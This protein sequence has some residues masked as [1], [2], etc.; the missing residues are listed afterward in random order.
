[1]TK[2]GIFPVN[3]ARQNLSGQAATTSI[4]RKVNTARPI[5]VLLGE[6]GKLLLRPQQ[7]VIGDPKDITGTKSPNTIVDQTLDD[8]QKALKNK[9]I[10]D[11]GCSRH[12]TGNKAYIVEYQDYNGG[13]VAFG[14]SKGY[15]SGKGKIKTRK[16]D[17]EDVCFVKELQHFN[18]FSVSQMCDK[19]NK[20]LFTDTECLVL[21]PDFK[22]PD[23]NQ[24]LL[25]VPR[26]NN[27]YSFN[28]EFSTNIASAVICLATNQK[29]NFSKLIFDGMLRNLDNPKKK[30]L[31]YL[32]F[33]MV[34]L[35]NQIE[36]GEP[37]NDVY[38]TP[39]HTLKVF[40]NM[41]RKGLK[42][43]GR[44]TP[45]FSTMLA[46]AEVEEGE[47]SSSGPD[48]THSPSINLEGTGG[49]EGD[50][51]QLSNDS[52]HSSGNTSERA[53]G[54]LNLEEL[55]SLCTNL[56]NRVLALETAKDAQ[57]AKI[58]K[59]NIRIKKLEKKCKPN[60]SHHK[61]WLKS[62]KM[63]SMKKRLGK[64]EPVSKQGRKNVKLGPTLDTFDDL[65]VDLVHGMDY[66]DTEEA[67]TEGRQS[68]ETGE[69]KG[70]SNEE[71]VNV[72]GNIGVSI[73][74]NISTASRP[75]VST[76]TPMT[77]PTITNVFEDE[78]IFLVDALVML[79]D[80]AKL[81]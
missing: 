41:S 10:V 56:S 28:L 35:N 64:K 14:G 34:F 17:F 25:R 33:L 79:S 36:L 23:E 75:E 53:E 5:L 21:S 46:S 81:K 49:N 73:V 78:D 48:N 58:L 44:I 72:A 70:G 42:F 2:T 66:M 69:Q 7:V 43:S 62:V 3:T 71:P 55:L 16:L 68:K 60:I 15:I 47:E 29:F 24:V 61:A 31:M 20:V 37:F 6:I 67:V 45:L 9:G 12:M 1:L 76:T 51:V 52:P 54:G 4:A 22:L 63:L 40:S 27:I 18:L 30:F 74:V 8:P 26:Q 38:I 11:S 13:P 59:L 57:A 39:A 65:D 32:R 19:K 80:K 77:L 50:H